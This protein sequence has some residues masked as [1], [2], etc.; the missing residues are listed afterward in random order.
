MENDQGTAG[1][2]IRSQIARNKA[3]LEKVL[4]ERREAEAAVTDLEEKRRELLNR[5][6]AIDS[7]EG[8]LR[9]EIGDL[10]NS[11][12]ALARPQKSAS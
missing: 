4:Q 9:K 6:A 12:D 7:R 3:E 10:Q 1:A 5:T 2:E 8:A 11:L